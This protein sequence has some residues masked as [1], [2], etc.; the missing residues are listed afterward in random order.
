MNNSKKVKIREIQSNIQ[1][2]E[3][4]DEISIEYIKNTNNLDKNSHANLYDNQ[5][6]DNQ[7]NDNQNTTKSVT[8]KCFCSLCCLLMI[9]L[10]AV[11]YIFFNDMISP[12]LVFFEKITVL[13]ITE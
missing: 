9:L 4:L 2:I 6:N 3:N 12:Y 1:D 8:C 5:N 7:N 11:M 10:F 13:N